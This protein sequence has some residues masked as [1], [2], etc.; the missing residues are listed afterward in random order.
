MA[1]RRLAL[2]AV[3]AVAVAAG[4]A[5]SPLADSLAQFADPSLRATL[6][7]Y[8]TCKA[9]RHAPAAR[10]ALRD[11]LSTTEIQLRY[12]ELLSN[13]CFKAA[14]FHARK[15][16]IVNGIY[17]GFLAEGLLVHDYPVATLP[18]LAGVAPLPHDT[19]PAF[20]ETQV[21]QRQRDSFARMR[22]LSAFGRVAECVARAAPASVYRFV[23]AV[24]D[25]PEESGGFA[26][27]Q[28]VITPCLIQGNIA[29]LP[30]FAWRF[31]L[32]ATLFQLVDRARPI[33]SEVP[34]A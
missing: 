23:T 7:E 10:V 22:E 17:Q 11:D 31:A 15:M 4:A 26:G 27:L 33:A 21:S 9:G 3:A 2:A 29:A 20:D 19:I 32:A 16:Q 30:A 6:R 14:V 24:P 5:A 34:H 12:P 28:P 18:D 8:A 13:E 25:S 1:A